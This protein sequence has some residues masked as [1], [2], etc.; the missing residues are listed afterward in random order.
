MKI[1]VF[2]KIRLYFLFGILFSYFTSSAQDAILDTLFFKGEIKI[3]SCCVKKKKAVIDFVMISDTTTAYRFVF[4]KLVIDG[5]LGLTKNDTIFLEYFITFRKN[6][7]GY[8][9]SYNYL[10]YNLDNELLI[11]YRQRTRSNDDVINKFFMVK[12]DILPDYYISKKCPKRIIHSQNSWL[13][14]WFKW[15]R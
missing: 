10:T 12:G 1:D 4:D 13:E 6:F 2:M 8:H 9:Y 11:V 5:Q 3:I 15:W 7:I 14:K